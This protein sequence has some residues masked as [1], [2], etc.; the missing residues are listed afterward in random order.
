LIF[1]WVIFRPR[2]LGFPICHWFSLYREVH[3]EKDY[4]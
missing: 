2:V 3:L 4:I 1:E